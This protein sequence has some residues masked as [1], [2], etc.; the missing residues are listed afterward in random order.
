MKHVLDSKWLSMGPEVETFEQ[1]MGKH[2]G[3]KH[4]IAVNNGTSAV[5]TM[6]KCIGITK[7]D[8]IIIPSLTYIAT[9]NAIIYNQGIPVYADVDTTLNLKPSSV[10]EYITDN[11]KAIMNIDYGGNP[12]DYQGLQKIAKKHD[13]LL[14]TDGAQSLGSKYHGRPCIGH[15]LMTSTSFHQAKIMTT[16]EGGMVFTDDDDLAYKARCIRNQGQTA[17]YIHTY[18]GNNYR[19]I[20]VIAAMGNT[21]LQRL[22]DT[23]Y[24]RHQKAMYYKEHLQGVDYPIEHHNTYN[25]YFFFNI[26]VKHRDQLMN[27]LLKYGV[28]TRCSIELSP[29]PYTKEIAHH[30][31]ALPLYNKLTLEEQNYVIR[32]VNDFQK[33]Q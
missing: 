5:D 23:V 10:K 9:A 26:I 20:D 17:R 33:T 7:G 11:T 28:E 12:A 31:L 8:E 27:H 29:Q 21:Q 13:I 6:M 24:E 32:T 22:P 4:A 15:G 14:I 2:L 3:I 1:N 19:M 30:L 16:I 25:S 18:L